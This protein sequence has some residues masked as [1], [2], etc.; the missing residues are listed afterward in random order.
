MSVG[1]IRLNLMS[2]VVFMSQM[3]QI[4]NNPLKKLVNTNDAFGL[5]IYISKVKRKIVQ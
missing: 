4:T 5:V 2:V 3:F 1:M